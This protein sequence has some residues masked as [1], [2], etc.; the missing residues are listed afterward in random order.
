V[1][2]PLGHRSEARVVGKSQRCVRRSRHEVTVDQRGLSSVPSG[3]QVWRTPWSS[4]VI[5]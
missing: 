1:L 3:R 4:R 5:V 2:G